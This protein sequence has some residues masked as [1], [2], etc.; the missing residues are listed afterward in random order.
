V[1]SARAH[2]EGG[3]GADGV[4]KAATAAAARTCATHSR[5]RSGSRVTREVIAA[6]KNLKVIGRAGVGVDNVDLE[7]AT[8]R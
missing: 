3:G 2:M 1:S 5:V 8:R 6:G 7:E 4:W